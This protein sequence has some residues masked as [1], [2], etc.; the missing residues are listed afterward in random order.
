MDPK[1][2]MWAAPRCV[3]GTTT[4]AHLGHCKKAV[5]AKQEEASNTF[6]VHVITTV[7]TYNVGGICTYSLKDDL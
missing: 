7:C 1:S 3:L 4:Q 6:V 2:C 5:E